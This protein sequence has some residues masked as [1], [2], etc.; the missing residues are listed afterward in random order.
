MLEAPMEKFMDE[1]DPMN[2]V[3]YEYKEKLTNLSLVTKNVR[4]Q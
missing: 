1:G 3:F 4:E 2:K